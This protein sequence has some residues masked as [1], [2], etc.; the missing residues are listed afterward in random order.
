MGDL[1]RIELFARKKTDGWDVWGNEVKSDIELNDGNN[2]I[3]PKLKSSGILPN[4]IWKIK[5]HYVIEQNNFAKIL[6]SAKDVLILN[7]VGNI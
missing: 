7:Y 5:H 1:P 3:P 6:E 2:G 4:F